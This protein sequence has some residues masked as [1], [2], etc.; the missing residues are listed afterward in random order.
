[1]PALIAGYY[2]M[3][4]PFPGYQESWGVVASAALLLI[5]CVSLYILF[6]RIDWL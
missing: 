3:N 6:R 1:M 4:V 5:A 2:G